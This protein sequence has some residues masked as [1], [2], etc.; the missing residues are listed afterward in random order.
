MYLIK[1]LNFSSFNF[2][3]FTK[4]FRKPKFVFDFSIFDLIQNFLS[5]T[6]ENAKIIK[7][8]S[9]AEAW[10]QGTPPK[11]SPRGGLMTR[12]ILAP[13]PWGGLGWGFCVLSIKISP[14]TGFAATIF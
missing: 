9:Q 3:F 13:S 11:S 7:Y 1:Y 5:Q 4:I 6:A 14:L 2:I 8:S 10:E 12:P